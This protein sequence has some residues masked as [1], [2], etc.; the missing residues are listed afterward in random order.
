MIMLYIRSFTHA[1]CW[2]LAA[3]LLFA[4]APSLSA[5]ATDALFIFYQPLLPMLVMLWLW[6]VVVSFFE[7]YYVRY[8]ACFA[9]EHL[10][11]LLSADDLTRIAESFTTLMSLSVSAYVLLVI[12]GYVVL[13]SYQPGV[14]FAAVAMLLANPLDLAQ[15]TNYSPQRWF[16]LD[17]LRRVVLPFQVLL[18]PYLFRRVVHHKFHSAPLLIH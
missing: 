8:D 4:V 15:D 17:T 10:K 7:A 6:T 9:T 12:N 16:F 18:H 1:L 5:G 13:A 3:A 11:F 14:F 2:A